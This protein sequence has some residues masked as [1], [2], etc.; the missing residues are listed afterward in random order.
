MRV[1]FGC[2]QVFEDN[3]SKLKYL[4]KKRYIFLNQQSRICKSTNGYYA[5]SLNIIFS[6]REEN[7][8]YSSEFSLTLRFLF[9]LLK[10]C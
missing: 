1:M 2:R 5:V 3:I 6:G 9:L 4:D 10:E 7:M 8:V